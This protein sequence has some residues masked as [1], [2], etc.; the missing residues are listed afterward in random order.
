MRILALLCLAS[1][2]A[3]AEPL[4]LKLG[5]VGSPGSLFDVSANELATE[6]DIR[7]L[8][9]ETL[10]T[11]LQLHGVIESTGPFYSLFKFKWLKNEASV[12]AKFDKP[13]AD[14]LRRVL[15]HAK[16]G[17]TLLN[18]QI[19]EYAAKYSSIYPHA[20]EHANLPAATS[21]TKL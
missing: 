14:F 7:P 19:P 10:L 4:E 17:K 8:V 6:H 11:Y 3:S 21:T 15:G 18:Q 12:L 13:R 1:F 16:F 2:A 9:V 5:H 20:Q